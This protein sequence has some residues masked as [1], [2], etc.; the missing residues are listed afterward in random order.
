MFI[1]QQQVYS[2]I[3]IFTCFQFFY[4]C[5]LAEDLVFQEKLADAL[6]LN[7]NINGAIKI[8]VPLIKKYASMCNICKAE[9]LHE[10][11]VEIDSL[12]VA[13]II[14]TAELIESIKKTAVPPYLRKAWSFLEDF[15]SEKETDAL[16]YSMKE[17]I[18]KPNEF[19]YRQGE[20]NEALYFISEG[21]FNSFFLKGSEEVPL[22]ILGPGSVAGH[23]SFFLITVCTSSLMALTT[24]KIN[25]ITGDALE[26][27]EPIHSGMVPKL[28]GY[29][30]GLK[31]PQAL[32]TKGL[33]RRAHTRFKIAGIIFFSI[34]TSEGRRLTNELRGELA[35]ISLG[36]LSFFIKTTSE[37]QA[38]K[39]LNS[40][41]IM[42]FVIPTSNG[43]YRTER[44]GRIRGV[45][46]K[47][48]HDYSLHIMF[49]ELLDADL[50]SVMPNQTI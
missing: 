3:I 49:D 4:R 46:A 42:K 27:I 7:G 17:I 36:G 11:L 23:E 15:L 19:V 2:I 26:K 45:I 13:E 31:R 30:L 16:F 10:K 9:K 34:V 21:R 5:V 38:R 47:M 22:Q 18:L 40:K 29:C 6:A 39:L 20:K 43:K 44:V 41:L 48:F 35:D 50:E 33:V 28:K 1:I 37:N 24:S 25:V 12:A 8:I 14:E 32:L